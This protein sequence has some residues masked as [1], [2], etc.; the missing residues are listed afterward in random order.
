MEL[1]QQ[2]QVPHD[3]DVKALLRLAT[4]LNIP[5][6]NNLSTADC[7][8]TLLQP[9]SAETHPWVVNFNTQEKARHL[10]T[11]TYNSPRKQTIIPKYSVAPAYPVTPSPRK[12]Y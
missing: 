2:L 9:R 11:T 7:V 4:L 3:A 6:A 12:V 10:P 1:S 5:V 8:L